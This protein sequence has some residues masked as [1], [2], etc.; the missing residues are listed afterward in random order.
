VVDD[1]A[2][3]VAAARRER[4]D[5]IL[6]D[7]QM[8]VMDGLSAARAI[9]GAEAE[10]GAAATPIIGLT[11][12]AMAEDIERC[13]QAGMDGH[14]AKPIEWAELFDTI[15]R[16]L[17]DGRGPSP[18][19]RP[20]VLDDKKLEE[21]ATFIGRERLASMLTVF[22]TEVDQRVL[23]L[24]LVAWPEVSARAHALMS[25]AGHFGFVELA[26]VCA[27]IEDD[28]R[29]G[30]GLRRFDDLLAAANRAKAAALACVHGRAA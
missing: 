1:G 26:R 17:K 10:T 9:R 24:D 18:E 8:P 15:D 30:C 16:L 3:A 12:N 29:K 7:L 13:R 6:L 14:V 2:A 27:D 21:L 11:A 5:M 25:L 20:P 22:V 28:V 4:Y 19:W 23:G